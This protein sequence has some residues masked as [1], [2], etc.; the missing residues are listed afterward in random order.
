MT[1]TKSSAGNDLLVTFAGAARI[2]DMV[3][4]SEEFRRISASKEPLLTVDLSGL[5]SVDVTFFQALLSLQ[6]TL[7]RNNRHLLLKAL[8]VEHPV[9]EA[10]DR[11]GIRLDHHFS[12]IGDHS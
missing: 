4:A 5:E 10:A 2:Q 7:A 1:V 6:L 8:P 3:E 9:A 12:R 11:L